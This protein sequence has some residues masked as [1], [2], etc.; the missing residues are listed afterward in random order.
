VSGAILFVA[1][2]IFS[3]HFSLLLLGTRDYSFLFRITAVAVF[4]GII[5]FTFDGFL[6]GM[7]KFNSLA[8]YRLLSQGLRVGVSIGLLLLGFGVA[9]VFIGWIFFFVTLGVL[10][11]FL[12]AKVLLG[13]R[14][15]N[16][17]LHVVDN[18]FPFKVL[19]SFSM[20]M[21]V[22]QLVTYLSD[23]IDRYVVLGLLGTEPLGVYTVVMTAASTIIAILVMPLLS[24]LIPSMSEVYGRVGVERLS[25]VFKL[26]SRYASL[27]FIPACFGFAVL[28]PLA[29][30]ILAG[31]AYFE[32]ILPLAMVSI[33]MGAYG[34]SAALLSSLTALGKT[35]R[36][37]TAVLL[38]SLIEF[39]LCMVFAPWLGVIGAAL[40]RALTYVAMFGLLI[41]FGSKFMTITID[42]EATAKSIVASTIMALLLFSM[43]WFTGYRLIMLPAYIIFGVAVYLSLLALFRALRST[44]IQFFKRIIPKSEILFSKLE[45]LIKKSSLLFGFLKWALKD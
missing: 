34:F 20:P 38:A 10:A 25:E 3:D 23:S 32:A 41:F 21:M 22:Y 42:G 2:F 16:D 19:F 27:M 15:E 44:D 36:V 28:S 45:K 5:G 4:V 37:A 14:K 8:L 39:A 26:S 18:P 17:R 29:V 12:T 35:L 11:A 1:S 43:A 24:T 7:Q 33:G 30:R 9:A 31:S 6:R 40:G 13:I